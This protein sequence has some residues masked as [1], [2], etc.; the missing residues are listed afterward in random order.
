LDSFLGIS[1]F[2]GI[3]AG[4]E[5]FQVIIS[6]QTTFGSSSMTGELGEP[7]SLECL[8]FGQITTGVSDFTLPSY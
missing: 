2:G 6:G 7:L 5:T 1:I 3:L 4:E 8:E